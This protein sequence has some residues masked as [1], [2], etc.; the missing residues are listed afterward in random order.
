MI[1]AAF[2]RLTTFPMTP[3]GK[4]DRKALPAPKT[5]ATE[6]ITTEPEGELEA[7]I[8]AIWRELLG[9]EHLSPTQNFFD[10]GGHSLLAVQMQRRLRDALARDISITEI[11]R[12]ST[13]KTLAQHIEGGEGAG[14]AN[15]GRNRARARLAARQRSR[16]PLQEVEND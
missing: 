6:R 10:L 5:G 13:I 14:A 8:A 15:R 1:P 9:V 11:F 3:N 7:T 12:F 2:V 4:I 16:T